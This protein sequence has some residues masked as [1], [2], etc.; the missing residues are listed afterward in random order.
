MKMALIADSDTADF[1]KIGGLEHI[2]VVNEPKDA[3]KILVDLIEQKKL[4]ILITTDRIAHYNRTFINEVIEERE[5]PI[6]ISIPTLGSSTYLGTDTITE[7]IRRKL[8][9]ELK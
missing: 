9:I 4:T 1:F 5:F 2:F 7:L 8:G 3:E 6:F